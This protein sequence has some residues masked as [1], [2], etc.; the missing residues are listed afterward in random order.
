MPITE[1]DDL[2]LEQE[3]L[4]IDD[5]NRQQQ[6]SVLRSRPVKHY[7]LIQ[8][9]EVRDMDAAKSLKGA[10][11]CVADSQLRPLDDDEF[12]IHDLIGAKV[13]STKEQYLGVV[14]DFF[15]AGS[16]G[17]CEVTDDSGSFLFPASQEVLK[18]IDPGRKVVINLLPGLVEL[19]R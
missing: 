5:G 17:V 6:F 15:E 14:T 11:V 7:W 1:D 9:D 18:E 19:N 12:F 4:I 3:H 8:F 13:Y 10:G 16:Q 2:F